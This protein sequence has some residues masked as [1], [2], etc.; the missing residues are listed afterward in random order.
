MAFEF[1]QDSYRD[2]S[3]KIINAG[4]DQ[5]TV[6]SILSDMQDTF[7]QG[8]ADLKATTEQSETISKENERLKSANMDL[9]LKLGTPQQPSA[10]NVEPEKPMSTKE[11]MDSYFKR[12]EAS[13]TK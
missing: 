13:K 2:F 7:Y 1:T 12:V 9:F 4:G 6:T 3:E 10:T 11:Y 5:A 8:I